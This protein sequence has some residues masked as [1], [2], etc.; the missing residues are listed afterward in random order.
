M[1]TTIIHMESYFIDKNFIQGT[2]MLQLIIDYDLLFATMEILVAA[3][4]YN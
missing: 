4:A 2:N 3:T 1:D